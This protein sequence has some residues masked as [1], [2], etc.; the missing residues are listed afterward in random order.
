MRNERERSE[1][2]IRIRERHQIEKSEKCERVGEKNQSLRERSK[3]E[4]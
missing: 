1:R 2:R 4:E 3:R